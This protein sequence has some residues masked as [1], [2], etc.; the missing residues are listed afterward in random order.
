M[1][2]KEYA[3]YKGDV[4]LAIGTLKECAEKLNVTESTILF[5]QF[6]SYQKRVKN[7]KNRRIT[8]LL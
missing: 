6:E 8:I 3:V 4:L 5:Y 2:E 1:T 7:P